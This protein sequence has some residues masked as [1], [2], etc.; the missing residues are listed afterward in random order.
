MLLKLGELKSHRPLTRCEDESFIVYIRHQ[1]LG[2]SFN[3]PTYPAILEYIR[4]GKKILSQDSNYIIPIRAG[5][6]AAVMLV[7]GLVVGIGAGY[8][9]SPAP[10]TKTETVISTYPTTIYKTR[11]Y[12][13]ETTKTELTTTTIYSTV[14]SLTT[15]VKTVEIP[16][17]AEWTSG[18][19]RLK[20]SSEAIPEK[21]GES[22]VSYTVKVTVKNVSDKPIARVLIIIFPYIGDKLYEHWN[23]ASHSAEITS[24]MPG[25]SVTH[26]FLLLPKDMTS[27]KITAFAL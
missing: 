4:S 6:L 26:E 22:I 12:T 24:L 1:R 14:I 10:Y 11:T 9:L 5:V 17:K 19:G 21:I 23:W 3:Q 20:V 13:R 27:Y 2:S 18:D 16:V 15:S 7:I 25:E 8:L